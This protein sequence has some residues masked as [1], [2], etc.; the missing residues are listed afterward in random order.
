MTQRDLPDP[1]FT[2]P[3]PFYA[4]V[5][6]IVTVAAGI[7]LHGKLRTGMLVI[8]AGTLSVACRYIHSPSALAA[9]TDVEATLALARA[10]L[11]ELAKLR[12]D[13]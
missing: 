9:R 4:A 6:A 7:F 8:A 10:A 1:C 2:T 11:P 5:A 3:I 13:S 12:R